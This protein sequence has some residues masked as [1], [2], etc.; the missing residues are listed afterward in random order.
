MPFF[1]DLKNKGKNTLPITHKKMTRFWISLNQ[2]VDFVCSSVCLME[3]REVFIPKIQS[4]K[5]IDFCKYIAPSTPVKIIGIRPPT[6]FIKIIYI[7][8]M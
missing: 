4:M 6:W 8:K 7:Q 5:I 2:G 1:L 3:G